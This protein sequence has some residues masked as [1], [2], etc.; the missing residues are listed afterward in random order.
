MGGMMQ[1]IRNAFKIEDLR[2]KILFTIGILAVY[3]VGSVI[4][5]PGVD[6]AKFQEIF[7]GRL[8]G[9]GTLFDAI[10]GH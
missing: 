1:T 9:I 3:R 10:S 2:K 4:P 6:I 5:V 7:V 8:G